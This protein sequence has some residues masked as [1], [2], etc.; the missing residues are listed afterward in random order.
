MGRAPFP[1]RPSVALM[2]RPAGGPGTGATTRT[3]KGKQ[4]CPIVCPRDAE[5]SGS[6]GLRLTKQAWTLLPTRGEEVPGGGWSAPRGQRPG[7]SI[8]GTWVSAAETRQIYC[9]TSGGPNRRS[10]CGWGRFSRGPSLRL[11]DGG[12]PP[13]SPRGQTST[14]SCVPSSSYR[15]TGQ[16]RT[17]S[18]LM[19]SAKAP[20]PDTVGADVGPQH[21]YFPGLTP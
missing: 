16:T 17:T 13:T 7:T 8:A 4:S 15:D 19:T 10:S 12:P 3:T 18:A 14:S 1:P 6:R 21:R 5:P 9:L 20:S 11:A 2:I